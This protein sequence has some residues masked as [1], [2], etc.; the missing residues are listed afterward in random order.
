MPAI[1]LPD[2]STRKYKKPVTPA[3]VAADIGP[4]LAKAAVA[5]R[6]DGLMVDLSHEVAA[7]ANLSLITLKDEDALALLRHDAAHV[8]A[9]A[10]L[11]L[12]P[13]TQVTI[14][15]AIENGFYYDFHREDSFT[16]DDL[17]AIETRMHEIVDRDEDITREV[18][19]RNKAKEFYKKNKEPFKV[20]LVDAIPK[21]EEVSFY[22]QGAFIDLCR[23]PHMP[24]TGRLGHAFKLMSVAGAYWRGDSSKPMLQRIYGTAFASDKELQAYLHMLE[25]AEK[26]DH[27]KLGRSLDFFHLQEEAAGS[28]F[29][30]PRGWV[31]YREIESYIR[32]RQ[33]AAGYREV[34]TPQLVDSSLWEASGHWDKFGEN[35]FVA[36]SSDDRTL[37]LKPMNCPGHVQIY[38]QGIT[39]Y[40]DLPIRMAEF[41]SCHRNEPSGALH[42]IM[43]V[44]AFT[45]DDAHI[46]CTE[47]QINSESVEFCNLLLD[48]Y[49][50]FGFEDVRVKFSD[51][52]ETRAGDDATWDKAEAALREAT[53]A[54]GLEAVSNPGEGAFYGP[55]LEFVLR[56]AIGRDW[57]CG[58][59]QVDFVLPERLDAEYVAEDGARHR[60]VMLHR[61]IVGSLERWIGILI[62]QYSG[63]MPTWLAPVQ[64]VIAPITEAANDY[65]KEV[66]G[67]L[68][69]AGV[70]TR[71]DLRNEKIGYKVR[72]HS[73]AKIPYILAVGAKEAGDKTVAMRRLGSNDQETLA[74]AEAV[75]TL[76]EDTLPPDLRRSQKRR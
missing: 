14:G 6:I 25:E 72:E 26:R 61:A 12:F 70:R 76:K 24:S 8:M 19:T 52:P 63:R 23:G 16:E 50:D 5:A 9:E 40:R 64:C 21:D 4:G 67:A 59:L 2:G 71:T 45:Q 43:R 73:L 34:K 33:D 62:E 38:R 51:R 29:W 46:F 11:E 37:A 57:Q 3:D 58:T 74:L 13:E 18:W 10:V 1:T 55:K 22:R 36:Q 39:S 68:G 28:V 47:E 17:A 65:A 41:G 69:E 7:D 49:R 54:A 27:R 32:R 66:A 35:M 44:R 53:E 20:E 75:D 30:H 42:G 31:L 48:I 60:P 15:P 56:D